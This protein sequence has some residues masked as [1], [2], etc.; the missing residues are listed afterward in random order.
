MN[1]NQLRRLERLESSARPLSI[2]DQ[3]ERDW[4]VQELA[5]AHVV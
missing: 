1:T 4:P 5:S 3:H 2:R